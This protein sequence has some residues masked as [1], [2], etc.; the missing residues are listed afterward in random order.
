MW[1]I[2]RNKHT[3]IDVSGI[4]FFYVFRLVSISIVFFSRTSRDELDASKV[5]LLFLYPT[6]VW[7]KL[8]FLSY[9]TRSRIFPNNSFLFWS[10]TLPWFFYLYFFDYLV[11]I[12]SLIATKPSLFL[13][14]SLRYSRYSRTLFCA[15]SFPSFRP[16]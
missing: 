1:F 3:T 5:L 2:L 11:I 6:E 4:R 7:G 8:L 16:I 15:Y 10:T 14:V 12:S 9:T 13:L